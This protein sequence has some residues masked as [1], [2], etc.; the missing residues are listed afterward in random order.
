MLYIC[1]YSLLCYKSMRLSKIEI[2]KLRYSG[3]PKREVG[4]LP[5]P[6]YCHRR[7]CLRML[8]G[9]LIWKV[10]LSQSLFFTFLVLETQKCEQYINTQ[11]NVLSPKREVTWQNPA[12]CHRR[13]CLRM[14]HFTLGPAD[15]GPSA[16]GSNSIPIT[17]PLLFPHPPQHFL[18]NSNQHCI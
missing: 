17:K 18:A 11:T 8:A 3:Q 5:K 4:D 2:L 1:S 16:L 15:K 13:S 10:L 12:P 14:L 7:G 6:G 9:A